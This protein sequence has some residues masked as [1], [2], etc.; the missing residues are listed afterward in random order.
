MSAESNNE[1][2]Y[3]EYGRERARLL[4]KL[5]AAERVYQVA[6]DYRHTPLSINGVAIAHAHLDDVQKRLQELD[7]RWQ[8]QLRNKGVRV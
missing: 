2:T 6:T 4:A 8:S 5:R 1:L 7:Q 3:V